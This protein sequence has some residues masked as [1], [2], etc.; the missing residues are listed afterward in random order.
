MPLGS[1]RCVRLHYVCTTAIAKVSA[2][3]AKGIMRHQLVLRGD[4]SL[5]GEP[6]PER[7]ALIVEEHAHL[8]VRYRGPA[9]DDVRAAA[10]GSL[11][12]ASPGAPIDLDPPRSTGL[13][14]RGVPLGGLHGLIGNSNAQRRRRATLL[15]RLGGPGRAA[16]RFR[17]DDGGSSPTVIFE[18]GAIVI[19]GADKSVT[20]ITE[21]A[22]SHV[23]A[24]LAM[25]GGLA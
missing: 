23:F 24:R 12:D 17:A 22:L 7:A 21:E 19:N 1:L 4:E 9:V 8:V 25:Q 18:P 10:G 11:A 5:G 3:R 6:L 2:T 20:E 15:R 14:D 16:A 13:L